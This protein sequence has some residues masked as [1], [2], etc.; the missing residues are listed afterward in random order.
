MGTV[1][2]IEGRI[3]RGLALALPSLV[4]VSL[5]LPLLGLMLG[6][7]PSWLASGIIMLS[8]VAVCAIWLG[9]GGVGRSLV[10][11][12]V[13]V[14]AGSGLFF[15]TAQGLTALGS[16]QNDAL[17]NSAN[18]IVTAL[19]LVLVVL[20]VLAFVLA[21]RA[22]PA[23]RWL[24]AGGWAIAIAMPFVLFGPVLSMS[25]QAGHAGMD[26]VALFVMPLAAFFVWALLVAGTLLWPPRADARK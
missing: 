17:N 9:Q 15:A 11:S 26:V 5:L 3:S 22:L 12:T 16:S 2:F 7:A 10:L 23:N 21:F 18:G 25:S 13:A 1:R 19:P 6:S 8:A 24:L 4:V 20:A 14:V